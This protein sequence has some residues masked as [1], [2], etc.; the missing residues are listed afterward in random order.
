MITYQTEDFKK[1]LQAKPWFKPIH[2]KV[3]KKLQEIDSK[4]H[5]VAMP[6]EYIDLKLILND[7]KLDEST[8][9]YLP[10]ES[11]QCHNNCDFLLAQKLASNIYCG[12]AMSKDGLWRFHSWG[13]A[14]SGE[15]IETTEPREKYYGIVYM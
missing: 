3:N 8:V 4:S 7:A 15:I 11:S 13:K 2:A 6:H 12:Y 10:L 1:R 9:L 5:I 14:E